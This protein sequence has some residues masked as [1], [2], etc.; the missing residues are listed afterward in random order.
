M[1]V[2]AFPTRLRFT[3]PT[4]LTR[5]TRR[6]GLPAFGG[7]PTLLKEKIR[8]IFDPNFQQAAE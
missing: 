6:F 3:E 8:A 7:K 4:C 5:G 1:A 2:G